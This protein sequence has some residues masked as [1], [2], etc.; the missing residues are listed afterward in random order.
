MQVKCS[1]FNHWRLCFTWLPCYG[2]RVR[3]NVVIHKMKSI[4]LLFTITILIGCNSDFHKYPKWYSGTFDGYIGCEHDTLT[5]H[6]SVN[7]IN[8]SDTCVIRFVD[9]KASLL[10]HS[11]SIKDKSISFSILSAPTLLEYYNNYIFEFNKLDSTE[12][13]FIQAIPKTNNSC[14]HL[15]Q[16]W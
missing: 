5:N 4:I 3:R 12:I 9:M 10:L 16:I 15:G 14:I 7:C 6:I 13:I 8:N 1:L 2:R 11:E